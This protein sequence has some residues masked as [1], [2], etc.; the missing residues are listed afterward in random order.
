MFI[1]FCCIVVKIVQNL[2][3]CHELKLVDWYISASNIDCEIRK[4]VARR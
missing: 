3:A 1:D 2:T 4:L